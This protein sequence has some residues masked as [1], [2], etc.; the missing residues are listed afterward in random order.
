LLQLK[1]AGMSQ[2]AFL[3]KA[4]ITLNGGDERGAIPACRKKRNWKTPE[5]LLSIA[6]TFIFSFL[7]YCTLAKKMSI[8]VGKNEVK[9]QRG[10]SWNNEFF[11]ISL[12]LF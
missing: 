5:C 11:L 8:I 3:Q 9:K 10:I 12:L 6:F 1:P 2:Q 7:W 4:K